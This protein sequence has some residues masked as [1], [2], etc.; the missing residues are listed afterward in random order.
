MIE[1]HLDLKLQQ[2]VCF[3][4]CAMI[5]RT[6][7][8][9]RKLPSIMQSSDAYLSSKLLFLFLRAG[10]IDCFAKCAPKVPWSVVI[11]MQDF[12]HGSDA[13]RKRFCNT[14]DPGCS[15]DFRQ[16][17]LTGRKT[18]LGETGDRVGSGEFCSSHE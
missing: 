13:H 9:R 15:A 4:A 8:M 18:C 6:A 10:L 3:S 11:F 2:T 5:F 16:L 7:G 1:N 14:Y 17:K 12:C